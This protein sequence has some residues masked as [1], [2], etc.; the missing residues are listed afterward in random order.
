MAFSL[1]SMSY[2]LSVLY[3]WF[4]HR[5]GSCRKSALY[6]RLV[7]D[8]LGQSLSWLQI[9]IRCN[10]MW[11]DRF[12]NNVWRDIYVSARMWATQKLCLP[13]IS[14]GLWQFSG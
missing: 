10:N 9:H 5:T 13:S 6:E 14:A 8:N 1:F 11:R 2:F 3:P 4:S 12:N 7:L